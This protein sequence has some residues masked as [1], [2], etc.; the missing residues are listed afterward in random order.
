LGRRPV[1]RL[2]DTFWFMVAAVTVVSAFLYLALPVAMS[3]F[4]S[5]DARDFLGPFPPTGF[6]LQWYEKLFDEPRYLVG[7]R[8][9]L[10]VST[11][12]AVVSTIIGVMAAV[13]F[14]RH[15]FAGKNLIVFLFLSPLVVPGVVTG[16]AI[17][18]LLA[19]VGIFDGLT[20]L[21]IGHIVI[22]VPYTVRTTLA[23]LVGIK[24]SLAEAGLTLGAD[25]RQVFW[26][27][28][29]PLAKTGIVA[30]TI[31]A[32]V[33]SLDDVSMSMFLTD[34]RTYTLPIA[35]LG[36]MRAEFDL[37]IAAAAVLLVAFTTLVVF[38]LDRLVGI[39]RV[40]GTGIYRG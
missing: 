7:V 11:T 2:G 25:E 5:F 27:I 17:L 39:D 33:F 3:V 4:M 19:S 30:G 20:R 29:F 31:F 32:F 21:L 24:P 6:S 1:K 38:A 14:E 22:T 37:A 12:A 8:V 35:L 28:T 34:A 13:A 23:G 36:N 9:S 16:F 26:E 10:I 18:M 15:S 40:L